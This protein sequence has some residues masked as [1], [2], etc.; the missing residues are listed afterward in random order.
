[1]PGDVVLLPGDVAL[2]GREMWLSPVIQ[3]TWEARVVEWFDV[4]STHQDN[5]WTFWATL[6]PTSQ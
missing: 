5:R 6:R 1:M 4:A 2:S 3:A